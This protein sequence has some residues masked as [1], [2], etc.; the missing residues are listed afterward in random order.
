LGSKIS[1]LRFNLYFVETGFPIRPGVTIL[2]LKIPE[3]PKTCL[4]Q[5]RQGAEGKN[6][7]NLPWQGALKPS[8]SLC[9]FVRNNNFRGKKNWIPAFAE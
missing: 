6:N 9:G 1:H 8:D 5:R 2:L 4:A 7:M 3:I